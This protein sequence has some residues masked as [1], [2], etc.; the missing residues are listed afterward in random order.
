MYSLPLEISVAA[1]QIYTQRNKKGQNLKAYLE[2]AVKD[3]AHAIEK[4]P[5]IPSNMLVISPM[6]GERITVRPKFYYGDIQFGS[7][8][9]HF[10]D[11]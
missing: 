2:T 8:D 10:L 7:I 5:R 3:I 11:T 9:G 1:A 6:R 4:G